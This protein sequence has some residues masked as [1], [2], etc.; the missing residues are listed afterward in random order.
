MGV[1]WCAVGIADE[2][3]D[4]SLSHADAEAE[5]WSISLNFM[6]NRQRSMML[7]KSRRVS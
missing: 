5:A 3:V 4:K 1:D 6:V 7:N 2:T